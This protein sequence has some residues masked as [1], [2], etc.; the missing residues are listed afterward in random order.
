L[1]RSVAFLSRLLE[2]GVDVRFADLPKSRVVGRHRPHY[3]A[4]LQAAGAR[5][6]RAIADSLNAHRIPTV[7]GAGQ[8]S[9][10]QGNRVLEWL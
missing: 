1:T 2:A 9:A 8:W 6:L 3:I 7:R 10:V 5:T 4:A